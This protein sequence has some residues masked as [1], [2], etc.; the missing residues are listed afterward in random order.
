MTTASPSS[1]PSNLGSTAVAIKDRSA[2][3]IRAALSER[4]DEVVASG[5]KLWEYARKN[6]LGLSPLA[7]QSGIPSSILS[8]FFNGR[9]AGDFNEIAKRIDKFFWRLDQKE[10][11]GGLREFVE[12]QLSTALW[13]TFEKTRIIRRIQIVQGPEQVGKT[14]S[15]LEYTERNNHGRTVYLKLAGGTR[16]GCGEFIWDLAEALGVPYTAKLREKRI[17]IKQALEACDLV[18]VDEAHL[19]FSWTDRTQADFWDYLRT[20]IFADGSRGIVLLATNQ[21]MLQGIQAWRRR[22]RYNVGQLLGRMR[23]EVLVIDPSED[24][25][26]EDVRALVSR[27]YKPG[28]AMVRLL[29]HLGSQEQLGHFGL[30]EDILNESWTRAKARKRPLTDDIVESVATQIRETLKGRK[31]L[32]E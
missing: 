6:N 21:P 3:D 10:A 24:V 25:T 13:S 12:T 16:S 9:Y 5:L 18:I 30:V 32:Y 14:R 2:D 20:D 22:S 1:V 23:N 11:Y 28:A 4:D 17:R 8:Q 27:Y 26:E 19:V 7:H 31:E 29:H 15:A